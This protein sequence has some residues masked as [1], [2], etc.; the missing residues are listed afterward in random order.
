ME[1]PLDSKIDLGL[2]NYVRHPENQNYIVFRFK[3]SN[4]AISFEEELN[5]AK[6]WFE[7][8]EEI[9]ATKTFTLFGIHKNDYTKV[10]KI[11][12]LVEAKHKKPL[13]PW[14]VFRYTLIIISTIAMTLALIGYC[15]A[16]KKLSRINKSNTTIVLP[17]DVN[18][19]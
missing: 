12:Y 19:K 17:S 13:I 14:S 4:R 10:E 6:I 1:N 15:D 7:K 5:S 16:Q 8:G 18:K 11:N 9:G 2:V 3:D